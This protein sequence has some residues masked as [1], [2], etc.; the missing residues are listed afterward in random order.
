MAFSRDDV[1]RV[2]YRR[3]VIEITCYLDDV[4]LVDDDQQIGSLT[5][6]KIKLCRRSFYYRRWSLI[7]FFVIPYCVLVFTEPGSWKLRLVTLL[8]IW[9]FYWAVRRVENCLHFHKS[10]NDPRHLRRMHWTGRFAWLWS[11]LISAAIGVG[12]SQ[13]LKAVEW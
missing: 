3:G 8:F 4:P 6:E 7:V 2:R 11:A 13:I 12:L 9:I 1:L 10:G 5:K